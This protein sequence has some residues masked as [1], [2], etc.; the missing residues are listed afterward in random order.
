MTA[1]DPRRL[2]N[3]K[4]CSAIQS[5]GGGR[6]CQHG[7]PLTA[8]CFGNGYPTGEAVPMCVREDRVF[9]EVRQVVTLKLWRGQ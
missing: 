5:M 6:K 8:A 4:A 1:P 7:H 9:D 3:Y 2:M